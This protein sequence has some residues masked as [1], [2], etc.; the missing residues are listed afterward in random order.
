MTVSKNIKVLD[1][2]FKL[3]TIIEKLDSK[4]QYLTTTEVSN[5]QLKLDMYLAKR[6]QK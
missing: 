6:N 5:Y 4:Y 1:K 2:T 3:L